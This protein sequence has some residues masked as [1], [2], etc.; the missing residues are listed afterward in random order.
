M[1]IDED[2][3]KLRRVTAKVR[4]EWPIEKKIE[5]V[6]KYLALGNL[7]LTAALTGVPPDTL[8]RWKAEGW[9][10]EMEREVRAS[11]RIE[12]D[13]KLS[14]IVD[15]ALDTISDRLENGEVVMNPAN[16][17]LVRRPVSLRDANNTANTLMQRQAILEK[18]NANEKTQE[19][20]QTIQ[21]QLSF[22]AGEF[23]KFNNRQKRLATTVD[24]K[25]IEDAVHEGWEEG[26][27]EGS[28]GV[29][30]PS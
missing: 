29:H 13:S 14:K 7:A 19:H 30:K 18:Q 9:W 6:T 16:G 25:E 1:I 22:L 28:E 11:R 17:E 4:G 5:A 21:E 3:L 24:Y 27:Q 10:K 26:L 23:A 20:Q 15:R 12:Q 2:K 8:K